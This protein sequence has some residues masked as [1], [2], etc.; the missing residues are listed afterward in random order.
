MLRRLHSSGIGGLSMSSWGSLPDTI[1]PW[2]TFCEHARRRKVLFS[3]YLCGL[4][5]RSSASLTRLPWGFMSLISP[6]KRIPSP[7]M[8]LIFSC[9]FCCCCSYNINISPV[10]SAPRTSIYCESLYP[11]RL[12]SFKLHCEGKFFSH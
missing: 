11:S 2:P 12:S 1:S 8:S 10:L 6:S 5:P 4:C 9:S 7:P 3:C